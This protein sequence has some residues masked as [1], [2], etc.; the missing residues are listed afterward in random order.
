MKKNQK[1]RCV[2]MKCFLEHIFDKFVKVEEI[3]RLPEYR[4][5]VLPYSRIDRYRVLPQ[6]EAVLAVHENKLKGKRF[7]RIYR[8][9][10]NLFLLI[11]N[12]EATG[13]KA[14]LLVEKII[15][16]ENGEEY[17]EKGY[18]FAPVGKDCMVTIATAPETAFILER[19]V[20][21]GWELELNSLNL[22]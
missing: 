5:K 6:Y 7:I 3:T 19:C 20:R 15:E 8:M 16:R 11:H 21:A 13:N 2:E 4:L 10:F 17:C 18:V 22:V 1:R 9:D 14:L 12:S